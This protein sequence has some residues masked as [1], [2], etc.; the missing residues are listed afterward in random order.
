MIDVRLNDAGGSSRRAGLHARQDGERGVDD[1]P[2]AKPVAAGG[3][4]DWEGV[5][6]RAGGWCCTGMWRRRPGKSDAESK[7]IAYLGALLTGRGRSDRDTAGDREHEERRAGGNVGI[8]GRVAGQFAERGRRRLRGDGRER[9]GGSI[10]GGIDR[11]GA[12]RYPALRPSESARTAVP[13]RREP[14]DSV[15][16]DRVRALLQF[17]ASW[18]RE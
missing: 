16:S 11:P 6:G 3:R 17:A 4:A 12:P 14:G 18:P 13:A 15:A 8:G 10:P 1:L 5:D 2:A 7:A 9:A